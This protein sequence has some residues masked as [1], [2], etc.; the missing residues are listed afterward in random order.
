MSLRVL[1]GL[2]GKKAN[3]V[4]CSPGAPKKV[5]NVGF[6]IFRREAK[7]HPDVASRHATIQWGVLI[8]HFRRIIARSFFPTKITVLIP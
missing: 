2:A 1:L 3:K 7:A 4:S 8:A 5:A 6:S